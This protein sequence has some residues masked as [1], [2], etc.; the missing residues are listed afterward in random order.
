MPQKRS[1]PDLSELVYTPISVLIKY[2]ALEVTKNCVTKFHLDDDDFQ[3]EITYDPEKEEEGSDKKLTEEDA[4]VDRWM[5]ELTL[6]RMKQS[7]YWSKTFK[8]LL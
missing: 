5:P 4:S 7:R 2:E 3:G 8:S 1:V 6:N